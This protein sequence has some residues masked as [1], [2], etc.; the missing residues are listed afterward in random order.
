MKY[1]PE[2][3]GLRAIAVVPVVLF[4]AGISGFDGGFVGVDVFF[5]ISGYLI[6]TIIVDEVAE[7]RFSLARFYERRA[8][9]I[10]P[11]LF[12]VVLVCLPFAWF[13]LMP[14]YLE[15]FNLSV[16]GVATFTS[17]FLFWSRTGYFETNAELQPLLHTWS[18]A[19]E[20]QY[21]IFFPILIML[22]W[23]FGARVVWATLIGLSVLSFAWAEASVRTDPAGAF[24]LLP[25]RGWELLI[26]ALAALW[27]RR[28]A[29]IS[30]PP[31]LRD[32]FAAFGLALVLFSIVMYDDRTVFPG[33]T[34]LLPTVGTVLLVLFAG[35]GGQVQRVLSL[36][37]LVWI[38]LISYGAYLWHQPVFAFFKHRFGSTSFDGHVWGLIAL[39]FALAIFSY[40]LVEQ[41]FR[42]R[43]STR[44]VVISTVSAG[45]AAV[46]VATTMH[47][48]VDDRPER[49]PSY[50]WALEHADPEVLRYVQRKNTRLVCGDGSDKL[51]IRQCEFGTADAPPTLALWGDS[52]AGALLSGLDEIARENGSA[53]AA[54]FANA[55]PPVPGLRNT[56]A[57]KCV[58]ET[59]EDILT[60]ILALPD[61]EQVIITGNFVGAMD[62]PNVLVDG[63]ATSA[64]KIEARLATVVERLK[65]RGVTVVLLEQGPLF[66]EPA[67]DYLVQSLRHGHLDP[68]AVTRDAHLASLAQ[69]RG[70]SE[71][72]DTYV[73]TDDFFCGP[74]VCSSIDAAGQLVIYDRNHVTRAY[75]RKLAEYLAAEAG[76]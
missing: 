43:I 39:S 56:V 38:G 50:Q 41:P 36:R 23:R 13:W 35:Q 75:S 59:H 14:R 42:R 7:G 29:Q 40:L 4:H 60:R 54:F 28:S 52:L 24:F 17:N 31:P 37:P 46:A 69:A 19:V 76:L 57:R 62:A 25:A 3:D 61:L 18:L 63:A 66:A 67:A 9:R 58:G 73:E 71:F 30:L 26:G 15:T 64:G 6:T 49:L 5:V 45:V 65:E 51:G 68:I 55:C 10:L 48:Y 53:G 2:I 44:S 74:E 8:R 11:V 33:T 12:F 34:A 22:I 20:E 70:L 27:L 72:V 32:V 16:L 1:R 21:Y 47:F